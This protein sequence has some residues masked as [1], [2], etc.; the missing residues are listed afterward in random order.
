[1]FYEARGLARPT[2][3]LRRLAC[4]HLPPNPLPGQPAAPGQPYNPYVTVDYMENVRPNSGNPAAPGFAT[5]ASE[6][7]NQPYA[8]HASQHAR[9]AS[10]PPLS[11]WALSTFKAFG[12]SS[13]N[14]AR[15]ASSTVGLRGL[16]PSRPDF[17]RASC[18]S[19]GVR[20]GM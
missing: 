20:L 7:R 18:N 12:T 3:L 11:K 4:P 10:G 8:A 17:L 14:A 9:Q 1:M 2:I 16:P 5:R 6:G 15:R 19:A 13:S